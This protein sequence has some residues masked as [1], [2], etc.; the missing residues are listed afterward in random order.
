MEQ[1]I[2]E[3]QLLKKNH[4]INTQFRRIVIQINIYGRRRN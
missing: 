4:K 1:V 3:S 2:R